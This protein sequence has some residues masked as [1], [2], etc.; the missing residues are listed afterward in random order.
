MSRRCISWVLRVVLSM[1]AIGS[2]LNRTHGADELPPFTFDADPDWE[3]FFNRLLP[4][5]LPTTRQE[6][7]YQTSQRAGGSRP[8]EIGGTIERSIVP[9]YYGMRIA[10]RSL[11]DKL[12]ASG[13]FVV[14]AAE[15]G[16]GAMIGWYN[17]SSRGWRTPN[18]LAMRIDG[19]GGKYWLFYE[20]GTRNWKTG[21]GGAFEGEQYQKTPTPPFKTGDTVHHFSLDYDPAGAEGRGLVTFRVDDRTY[22]AELAEG[23][24]ADG[25]TFNRFGIWNVQT[26]G[27]P[28]EV[29]LDDLVIDGEQ[30]SFDVDARWD[31]LDNHVEFAERV[32]RPYHDFGFSTTTH[33]GGAAGEVGGIIFRDEQP[34]YYG[35]RTGMLTLNDEL[36]ASGKLAF[37]KAGSD[38]GVYLGWFNSADKQKHDTP[39]YVVRQKN[40]LAALIEGPSRV[41]HY[42][43]PSY[44]V[45]D[46]T[47][48]TAEGE[49]RQ[50]EPGWPVIR[51]DSKV[52]DWRMHYRPQG[53][54][55]AGQIELALDGEA[56]TLDLT[57]AHRAVGA[58]FDRFGLFNLQAGGHHVELYIDDV[59]YTRK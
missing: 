57:P 46:G 47:G 32:I 24:R 42:F 51:P 15:G 17:E 34:A 49:G 39:E 13:K 31:A 27:D 1:G 10:P 38:S 37:L 16:S 52:H 43:R 36:V 54:S 23:H 25:A 40:Y 41:G 35:A 2:V 19:N 30:Q 21:G 53:G 28:L 12:S 58:T 9:A 22:R 45:L 26:P 4:A 14:P 6:F 18:S 5:T 8:G 55:G 48:Q 56:H 59:R 20:Y 33:C 7:G 11:E 44:G 3:G 50:A 29:Y